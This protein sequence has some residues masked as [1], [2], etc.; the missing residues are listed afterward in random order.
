MLITMLACGL[1]GGFIFMD[2]GDGNTCKY[3]VIIM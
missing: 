3:T 2:D 1:Y